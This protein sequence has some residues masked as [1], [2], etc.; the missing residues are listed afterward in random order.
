MGA[1]L[2]AFFHHHDGELGIELLEPDRGRKPGRAG[3][4]HHNVEFHRL[5]LGQI[6]HGPLLA[7]K[8]AL[9]ARASVCAT[10]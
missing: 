3:A 10:A 7:R 1:D 8:S 9:M 6:A 4:D 5:A 2:G